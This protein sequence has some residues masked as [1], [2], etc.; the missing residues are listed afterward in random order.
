MY[1][2]V[3]REGG[4]VMP[5]ILEKKER[6]AR[7]EHTCNYC[8]DKIEKGERY[9]WSKLVDGRELYEWKSHLKCAFIAGELWD[10]VDPCNGMTEDDFHCAC[11]EICNDFV[12]SN[13]DEEDEDCHYCLDKL[14]DFLQINEFILAKDKRNDFL[15]W[16]CTPREERRRG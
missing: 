10:Y 1:Q 13:C 15:V 12:C 11:A 6:V 2:G 4:K 16:R 9:D 7:K 3:A 14:Y 5:E 8:S